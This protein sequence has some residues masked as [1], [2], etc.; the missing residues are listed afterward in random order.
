MWVL[1][2]I[3][4][5]SIAWCK[6]DVTPLLKHRSYVSFALSYRL[7]IATLCMIS[8]YDKPC[9]T[10]V[11]LYY[12]DVLSE[13]NVRYL[14]LERD[15]GCGREPGTWDWLWCHVFHGGTGQGMPTALSQ[16]HGWVNTGY[17][18][19]YSMSPCW[20]PRVVR[21]PTSGLSSLVAPK[22]GCLWRQRLH[23]E[24]SRV[25]SAVYWKICT[26][27]CSVICSLYYYY[28]DQFLCAFTHILQGCFIGIVYKS[29]MGIPIQL[30]HWFEIFKLTRPRFRLIFSDSYLNCVSVCYRD[31]WLE[32]HHVVGSPCGLSDGA[33]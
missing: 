22:I 15:G 30:Y 20:T 27:F 17:F 16:P 29:T 31:P 10:D 6:R 23:Y 18:T 5:T 7:T 28:N 2:L 8:C 26:R 19:G 1:N 11:P 3:Y 25:F 33:D 32:H 14:A 4:I 13:K 12:N 9:Y 24:D 21:M